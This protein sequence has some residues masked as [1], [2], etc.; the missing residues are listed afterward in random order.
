M[1]TIRLNLAATLDGFIE[2]KPLFKDIK[3]KVQLK[4]ICGESFKSGVMLLTYA[5]LKIITK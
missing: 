5:G 2:G 1:R 3:Q 4:L